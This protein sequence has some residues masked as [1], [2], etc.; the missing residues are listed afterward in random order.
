MK[1]YQENV[2]NRL[3]S[4]LNDYLKN[5][6]SHRA[7]NCDV[8]LE[9]KTKVLDSYIKKY[10]IKNI[11]VSLSGGVDSALVAAMLKYM[12]KILGTFDIYGITSPA[13]NFA[14][15]NQYRALE[16]AK[17]QAMV[18]R[19]PLKVVD[20]SEVSSLMDSYFGEVNTSSWSKGQL[21]PY[22]RT[23]LNYYFSTLL[24]DTNGRTI[25]CGTT[26][27]D[28]GAYLGYVGKASDYIVDI[29]L[30]SDLHKSEVYTLA[31]HLGVIDEIINVEPDGDMYDGRTDV[32]VFGA[33]YDF[34]EL[35]LNYLNSDASY[36]SKLESDSD[37]VKF[38]SNIEKLH[39]Y[40][41]HKYIIGSPSVH[42]DVLCSGVN[43]GWNLDFEY[44]Y[45]D[46]LDKIGDIHKPAF[47]NPIP[48]EYYKGEQ[49]DIIKNSDVEVRKYD[50][51]IMVIDGLLDDNF[52]DTIH[53]AFNKHDNSFNAGIDGYKNDEYVMSN[54]KSL[55]STKLSKKLF[56]RIYEYIPILQVAKEPITDWNKD[57]VYRCIGINPLFRYI[58]YCKNGKLIPHYDYSF[59]DGNDKSLYSIV[60]YL[61]DSGDG[62]TAFMLDADKNNWN[63]DLADK[64][65]FNYDIYLKVSPKRGRI[66]VFPHHLLHCGLE[67]NNKKTILRSDLMFKKLTW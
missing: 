37:F 49:F 11:I 28:E 61:D 56:E 12:S 15:V 53:S 25:I 38:K 5:Y 33:S 1:V 43:G 6:R 4:T 57:D 60:I 63:K 23:P 27:R 59:I 20:I 50:N 19:I 42:M 47:V 64:G 21:V 34:V 40:N 17:K 39:S 24:N 58:D 13:R 48:F 45:Y 3:N 67:S 62:E 16:Y 2:D 9:A 51:D 31:K 52:I 32:E 8:Y 55:Y 41:S 14:V 26:N 65:D 22:M 7:F 44:D 54:R 36:K 30:I 10:G 29:Q 46:R 18:L 35:Y 66:I